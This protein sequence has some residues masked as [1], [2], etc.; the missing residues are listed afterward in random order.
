MERRLYLPLEAIASG[1]PII[2]TCIGGSGEYSRFSFHPGEVFVQV[3]D[4]R[5]RAP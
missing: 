1:C 2:S 4:W 5:Q 3:P